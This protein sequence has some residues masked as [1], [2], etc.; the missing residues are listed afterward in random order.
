LEEVAQPDDRVEF[1]GAT[2][3][4]VMTPEFRALKVKQFVE[5]KLSL[6][7]KFHIVS[8]PGGAIR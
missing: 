2:G 7:R 3:P 1:T 5:R 4:Q 8:K 6:D